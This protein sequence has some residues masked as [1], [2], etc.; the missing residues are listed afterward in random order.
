M[1]KFKEN[2]PSLFSSI[3]ETCR[4][5]YVIQTV[6]RHVLLGYQSE[7]IQIMTFIKLVVKQP[8][9]DMIVFC[10]LKPACT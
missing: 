9:F 2:F 6:R 8:F 7:D 10:C 1:E 3:C 5:N 4:G